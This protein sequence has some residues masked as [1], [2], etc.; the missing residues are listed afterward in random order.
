MKRQFVPSTRRRGPVLA[1]IAILQGLFW[2]QR[3]LFGMGA[4]LKVVM[5][6]P[7][8]AF[9]MIDNNL[10]FRSTTDSVTSTETSSWVAING[11]PAI[12]LPVTAII[13][14]GSIGDTLALD[15]QFSTDASNSD[16]SV[17][18]RLFFLASRTEAYTTSRRITRRIGGVRRK[19][20]R[21]IL[22]VAGTSPDFGAI[23]LFVDDAHRL[24][25]YQTV[26]VNSTAAD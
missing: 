14:K 9:A 23:Q 3:W 13:P 20:A 6:P 17:S 24:D 2:P 8:V 18:M 11:T 21:T 22:T 16:P 25:N 5:T 12:G 15:L 10:F 1:L 19:Y 7:R 26:G 4:F